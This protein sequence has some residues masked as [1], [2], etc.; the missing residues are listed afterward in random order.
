MTNYLWYDRTMAQ[1]PGKAQM[2]AWRAFLA[3]HARVTAAL[4]RELVAERGLPLAWYDVL[5]Q[6]SE[7]PVGRLRMTDLAAAVL[8]SKS[9]L[10]RLVDRMAEAGLVERSPN[11]ADR[12]G[13]IVCLTAAGTARLREAAPVHLRGVQEHFGARLTGNDARLLS[14]TLAKVGR[15]RPSQGSSA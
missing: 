3:A 4:E 11:D 12:R 8:L 7:A 14:E 5:V 13:R 9:G 6:L 1:R 2:G 10:T 15:G